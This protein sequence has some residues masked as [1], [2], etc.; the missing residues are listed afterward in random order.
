[1]KRVFADTY[2]FLAL[3]KPGDKA[4]ARSISTLPLMRI[5]QAALGPVPI[6]ALIV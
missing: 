1:M 2:Y 6:W 5:S 4:H 3:L